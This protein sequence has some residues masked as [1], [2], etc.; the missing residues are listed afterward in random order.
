MPDGDRPEK[1]K[2]PE[3]HPITEEVKLINGI[4]E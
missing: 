2:V 1:W 4:V 3:W